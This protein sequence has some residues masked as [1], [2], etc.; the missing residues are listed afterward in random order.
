MSV[1]EK[2]LGRGHG[3]RGAGALGAVVADRHRWRRPA[4]IQGSSGH[5]AKVGDWRALRHGHRRACA[6]RR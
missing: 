2:V 3:L 4:P 6:A 5:V 1:K